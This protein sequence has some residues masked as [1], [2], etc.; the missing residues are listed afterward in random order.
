MTIL[1]PILTLLLGFLA[2]WIT[3]NPPSTPPL[4][5]GWIA[6][7][8][9]ITVLAILG[10]WIGSKHDE[11]DRSEL[12]QLVTDTKKQTGLLY[13]QN[14][15]LRGQLDQIKTS[16]EQLAQ[17]RNTATP[18]TASVNGQCLKS[19][20]QAELAQLN[21]FL[22]DRLARSPA[23]D[24]K[25]AG[26][27]HYSDKEIAYEVETSRQYIERFWPSIQPILQRAV[28]AGITPKGTQA[29]S[30]PGWTPEEKWAQAMLKPGYEELV[31]INQQSPS[32]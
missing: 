6:A 2:A 32:C 23:Y 26:D 19:D 12:T 24:P 8:A 21:V 17:S 25:F 31:L 18:A 16:N 20:S 3:V 9:V 27:P 5:R 30:R 13:T 10:T 29:L 14:Q 15:D 11:K 1:A 4:R 28:A 7:F 22:R